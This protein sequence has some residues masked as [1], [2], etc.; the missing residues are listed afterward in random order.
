MV[1]IIVP[2]T[3]CNGFYILGIVHQH[4]TGSLHFKGSEKMHRRILHS[5]LEQ[6]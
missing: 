4:L 1:L 6:C 2:E 3:V 5:F